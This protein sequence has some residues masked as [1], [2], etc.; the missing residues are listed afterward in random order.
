MA[1]CPSGSF[2][3]LGLRE[4]H[5][6]N[7]ALSGPSFEAEGSSENF[8]VLPLLK[9]EVTHTLIQPSVSVVSF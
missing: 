3:P 1:G 2:A 4:V 5:P 9:D 8:L 7:S 6:F